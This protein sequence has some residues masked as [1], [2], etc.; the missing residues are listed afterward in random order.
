MGYQYTRVPKAISSDLE[1]V[2]TYEILKTV[3]GTNAPHM[4]PRRGKGCLSDGQ[5]GLSGEGFPLEK[6]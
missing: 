5:F 3:L 1:A 6:P 2:E 4:G